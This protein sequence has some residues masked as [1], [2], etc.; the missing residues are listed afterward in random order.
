MTGPTRRPVIA[1]VGG[2]FTGAAVAANLARSAASGSAT[3]IVFEPRARLGAGLAYDTDNPAHRINVPAA[4]MSLIPDDPD[5]FLNWMASKGEPR[6]DPEVLA[7]DGNLYPRRAVFG[8]YVCEFV[9]PFLKSGKVEHRRERVEQIERRENRWRLRS[10]AGTELLADIVVVAT[11]HPAPCAPRR[12][13][14]ALCGHPRYVPDSTVVDALACI[15][16]DD[17]VLVVGNGLTAADVIASLGLADHC[18]PIV[19]LSR[20]G[21]RSRGHAGLPQELFG[22]FASEP[23][24]T[25]LGLLKRVRQAVRDAADIGT[26]WHGVFD[27]LRSQG[28][29][30][31]RALPVTE[32]RRLV[33]HLRPFWD[34]HRFR[35]APQVDGAILAGQEQGRIR[36]L[37]AAIEEVERR[38]HIIAVDIRHRHTGRRERLLFDACVV[39]TGPAHTGI[40]SSQGWLADLASQGWL[41]LDD[42]GLGLACDEES[43]AIGANGTAERSLIVAGP[44]ARGTFGE[45][46]GLPQVNDHAIFVAEQIADMLTKPVR[47]GPRAAPLAEIQQRSM[48]TVGGAASR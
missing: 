48:T 35:V 44:L 41:R 26:S 29:Q 19:A 37:G 7:V 34:V 30:I 33:R 31:W 3:I 15:R 9:A 28:G 6:G 27:A 5:D 38:G 32:R 23:A 12:V 24:R 20:R 39:T 8:R 17:H 45:L 1:I 2:G 22:D 13:D 18:G 11:T 36:I 10:S 25:A 4:R 43:R 42:V 47:S 46:M 40:L 14:Q 16:T 21:L